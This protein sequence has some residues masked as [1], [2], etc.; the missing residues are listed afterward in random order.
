MGSPGQ[1]RTRRQ[2]MGSSGCSAVARATWLPH[3]RRLRS[4]PGTRH[5][6]HLRAHRPTAMCGQVVVAMLLQYIAMQLEPG[7]EGCPV[8]AEPVVLP[9]FG[10]D[11]REAVPGQQ[12]LGAFQYIEFHA[13][14]INLQ[15]PQIGDIETVERD[16]PD[17]LPRALRRRSTKGV[18]VRVQRHRTDIGFD[19]VVWCRDLNVSQGVA[20]RLME[21]VD[22]CQ[23]VECDST[24]QLVRNE[25]LCFKAKQA[26]VRC[27]QSERDCE[28]AD[29]GPDV[30][31][32]TG[33][34]SL[35][36][37]HSHL[38]E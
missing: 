25:S 14:D 7:N 1:A 32:R 28:A 11:G 10:Q 38:G 6:R 19:G 36:L 35:Q 13:F 23:A 24:R 16:H 30:D 34:L 5:R 33:R 15:Q 8:I 17:A 27:V 20:Y 37:L 26:E 4:D 3:C 29:V 18:D 12:P 22:G 31:D 21:D 9:A 2:L